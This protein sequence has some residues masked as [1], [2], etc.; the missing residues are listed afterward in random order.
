MAD[1]V[2]RRHRLADSVYGGNRI[3]AVI[4]KDNV[5]GCQFHPEKSGEFGLKIL[6]R[7]LRQ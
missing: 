4:T 1:P 5:S 2:D 6:G 3:A 7:F